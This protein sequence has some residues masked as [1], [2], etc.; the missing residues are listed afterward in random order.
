MILPTGNKRRYSS[1]DRLRKRAGFSFIE[2]M[3]TTAV[4][5]FGIVMIYKAFLVSLNQ[6]TYINHR[7]YAMAL[8]DNKIVSLQKLFEA[9]KEIPFGG[10]QETEQGQFGQ[11]TVDFSYA[12]DFK[13]VEDLNNIFQLDIKLLWKEGRHDVGISRSVYLTC[14]R[15]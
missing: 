1:G 13:T 12:M 3:V 2:V 9:S 14:Y 8:L 7:L 6:L 4:L 15:P 10:A 11:K 5:S